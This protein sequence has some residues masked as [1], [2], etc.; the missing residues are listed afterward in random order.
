MKEEPKTKLIICDN[1]GVQ[2][3]RTVKRPQVL[4][5]GV[6][7]ILVDKVP[8]VTCRNCGESYMTSETM[9]G[10][11]DI[12]SKQKAKPATRK[13]AVTEFVRNEIVR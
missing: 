5:R 9:H 10:L 13:I 8:V 7:M 1:C 4:G 2:A 3:A 11:D 12:R 6:R